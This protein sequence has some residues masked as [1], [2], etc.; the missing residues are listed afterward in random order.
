MD[1]INF[2]P[3][4]RLPVLMI[5]SRNDPFYLLETSQKPMFEF[6]GTPKK[7]KRHRLYNAP[8][9]GVPQDMF[10]NCMLSWLDQYLGKVR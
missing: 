2:V 4:V 7:D 9:H 3:R 6:L 5:N 1:P 8:G 10:E